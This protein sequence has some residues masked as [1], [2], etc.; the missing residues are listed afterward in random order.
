MSTPQFKPFRHGEV[1]GQR[2][3]QIGDGEVMLDRQGRDINDIADVFRHHLGVSQSASVPVSD[4]LHHVAGVPVGQFARGTASSGKAAVL[5]DGLWCFASDLLSPTAASA[6][7]V[8]VTP[9]GTISR[10]S[11][12]GDLVKS[13]TL[14]AARLL[15]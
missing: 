11:A 5:T 6:D 9:G 3:S 8:N 7:W 10:S 4:E 15:S 2:L 14:R 13:S 1:G 12:T